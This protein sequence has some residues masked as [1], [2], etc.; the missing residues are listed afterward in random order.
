MVDGGKFPL[1]AGADYGLVESPNARARYDYL[2]AGRQPNGQ[3]VFGAVL[4][5][6]YWNM[7]KLLNNNTIILLNR[8]GETVSPI[9][10]SV[11]GSACF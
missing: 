8:I 9:Q 1:F 6:P 11:S 3:N 4:T 5:A 10:G 2:V 7:A